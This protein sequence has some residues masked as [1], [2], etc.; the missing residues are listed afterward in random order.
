MDCKVLS[1][2]YCVII[3]KE[4]ITAYSIL[5]VPKFTHISTPEYINYTEP[6]YLGTKFKSIFNV[7]VNLYH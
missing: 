4:F 2:Y 5:N 7:F 3:R 1:N 6:F